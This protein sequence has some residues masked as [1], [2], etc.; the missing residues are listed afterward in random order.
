[1]T[2][3][4]LTYTAPSTIKRPGGLVG[5]LLDRLEQG[6]ATNVELSGMFPDYRGKVSKAR[7]WLRTTGRTIVNTQINK[8]DLTRYEIV[9]L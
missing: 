8:R 1:M 5:K 4:E 7:P 2:Q 3:L 6:P 9:P